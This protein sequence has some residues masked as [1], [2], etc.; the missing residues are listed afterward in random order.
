[1]LRE[2]GVQAHLSGQ[3]GFTYGRLH[4]LEQWRGQRAEEAF[5]KAWKALPGSSRFA[6]WIRG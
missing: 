3:N 5:E 2:Y 4:A 1:M 6:R